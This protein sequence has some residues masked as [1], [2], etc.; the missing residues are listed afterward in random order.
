MLY[1]RIIYILPRSTPVKE[2][3]F[4]FVR[5][6]TLRTWNRLV[7][8]N[9]GWVL[10]VAGN[11]AGCWLPSG[12]FKAWMAIKNCWFSSPRKSLLQNM[13]AP[14]L[15]CRVMNGSHTTEW[16]RHT[17]LFRLHRAHVQTTSSRSQEGS[18]APIDADNRVDLHTGLIL[19]GVHYEISSIVW[20]QLTIDHVI[21]LEIQLGFK[22]AL[23]E[24]QR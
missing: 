18:A 8:C 10:G 9:S 15:N 3:L 14:P 4:F 1:S 24:F 23:L 13:G 20:S 7:R 12:D 19:P 21:N 11:A 17:G 2:F 22:T 16:R 6:T 5:T